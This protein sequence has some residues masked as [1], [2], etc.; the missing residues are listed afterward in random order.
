MTALVSHPVPKTSLARRWSTP[1]VARSPPRPL[2]RKRL[3]A[4]VLQ[5]VQ[6]TKVAKAS[7]VPQASTTNSAGMSSTSCFAAATAL[8]G[9]A[10]FCGHQV[11]AHRTRR[12]TRVSISALNASGSVM[13]VSS[14]GRSSSS[15][16]RVVEDSDEDEGG[17]LLGGSERL[18]LRTSRRAKKLKDIVYLKEIRAAITSGEFALSLRGAKQPGLIDYQGLCNRLYQFAERLERNPLDSEVLP[19]EETRQILQRL[20]TTRADLEDRVSELASGRCQSQGSSFDIDSSPSS[21]STAPAASTGLPDP[22]KL[23]LYIREDRTVDLDGAISEAERAA[24]FSRDL[25]ERLNG[26][27]HHAPTEESAEAQQVER[28]SILQKR[29]AL[30]QACVLL[31]KFEKD[32]HE[33][34]VLGQNAEVGKNMDPAEFRTRLRSCEKAARDYKVRA[35][36]ANIEL[37]LERIAA[38][39]EADLQKTNMADWSSL[40]RE[41]K[42]LVSEFSLLDKQA[43]S[44]LHLSEL[45]PDMSSTLELEEVTLLEGDITDFA[46]RVGLQTAKSEESGMLSALQGLVTQLGKNY[47]KAKAG[48][49]FYITGVQLLAQDVQYAWRLITKAATSEYTLQPREVRTLQRTLKDLATLIPFLIILIIPMT[50]VGHVL[51]FSFIQKSFPEFFPSTFTERRQNVVKIYQDIVPVNI[52]TSSRS[53]S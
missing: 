7:S 17:H 51:V 10:A 38:F 8:F 43:S 47:S 48:L 1:F 28:E 53:S 29:Q 15:S 35:V 37:I 19:E 27:D 5:K 41:L 20:L 36:I 9:T 40:G 16:Q 52:E 45:D 34:L 6:G 25:W 12:R 13:E 11:S 18:L 3:R 21:S 33:L 50:P 22:R 46:N 26:R 44:Y 4:G 32:R 23:L 30:E 2:V 39:I 14:F 24:R 42:L 49:G 31:D